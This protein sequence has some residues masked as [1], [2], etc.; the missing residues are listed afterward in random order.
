M[1]GGAASTRLAFLS[2]SLAVAVAIQSPAADKAPAGSRA[3]AGN[4]AAADE[5]PAAWAQWGGP[6][7]DFMAPAGGLATS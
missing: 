5:A 2:L 1:T 6:N 4:V 3:P 7:Q